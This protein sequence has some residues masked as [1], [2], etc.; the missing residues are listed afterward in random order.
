MDDPILDIIRQ[1][2][3]TIL[4]ELLQQLPNDTLTPYF[5]RFQVSTIDDMVTFLLKRVTQV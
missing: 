4:R 5:E 3:A 2:N 1:A